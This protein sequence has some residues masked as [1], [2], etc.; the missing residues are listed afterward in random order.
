MN[1]Y[2]QQRALFQPQIQN[3]P[4]LNL[5]LIVVIPAYD[6]P[7]LLLSLMSLKKC[8]LPN[9]DV[10]VIVVVN[11]PEN[12]SE[13][14]VNRNRQIALQAMEWAQKNNRPRLKFFILQHSLPAKHAGVGLARKIGMDEA[15]W[16]LER[17]RKPQGLIACFD[18]DS[19][20]DE[21]YF[22]ALENHFAANPKC[23]ACSIYFEHPLNGHDFGESVYQAIIQYELHLRYYIHAQRYAGFPHAYHTVGSSMAVR[24]EAY[25]KQGG[26]NKRKAGEDFY[27]IHKFTPLVGFTQLTTTRVIPSARPSHRVPFGTG[28]AIRELK[29]S[30]KPYL[31]YALESFEELKAFLDLIPQMYERQAFSCENLPSLLKSFLIEQK[32]A[33]K[34]EEIKQNARSYRTF[35][36]RFF[37][38]FNAFMVMKYVHFAREQGREDVPAKEAAKAL[39]EKYGKKF[40]VSETRRILDEFRQMDISGLP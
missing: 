1:A 40:N 31:T 35:R 4:S 37:R 19:R 39:L 13:A 9:C 23:P 6:E 18:A 30:N 38:W 21:N 27:F 2:L 25:Q 33:Q 14:I 28:K 10:E 8:R 20:C 24:A 34:L 17:V 11:E 3:R 29:R 22:Q 15:C 16:R 12:A 5:G 7:F 36:D 26:M 32:F